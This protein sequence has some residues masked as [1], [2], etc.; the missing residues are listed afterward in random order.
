MYTEDSWHIF[1]FLS[2]REKPKNSSLKVSHPTLTTPL[3]N[4]HPSSSPFQQ[5]ASDAAA[6]WAS[7]RKQALERATEL[8]AQRKA[9][10]RAGVVAAP[11]RGLENDP[12]PPQQARDDGDPSW[13]EV[14]E[15]PAPVKPSVR[16]VYKLS[17]VYP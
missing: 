3:P 1:S 14:S 4:P 13:W 15:G 5:Q 9:A 12:L 10:E 2:P 11:V 16:A 7:K 6:D 17:S 8:R